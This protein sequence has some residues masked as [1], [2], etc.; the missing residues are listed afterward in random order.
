M[1]KI[2]LLDEDLSNIGRDTSKMIPTNI[3]NLM[4][5]RIIKE[6]KKLSIKENQKKFQTSFTSEFNTIEQKLFSKLNNS[7]IKQSFIMKGILTQTREYI[8][9]L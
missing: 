3:C 7:Y 6:E 4:N 2:S 9:V 1:H 8:S 5:K